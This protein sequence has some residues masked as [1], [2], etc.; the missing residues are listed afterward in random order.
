MDMRERWI[1]AAVGLVL[2]GIC[3]FAAD[4][5]LFENTNWLFVVGVAVVSAVAAFFGGTWI[6]KLLGDL[7]GRI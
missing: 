4:F 7:C 6:L 1:C 2:G 5:Y 3:G